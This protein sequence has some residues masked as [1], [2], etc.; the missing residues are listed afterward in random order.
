MGA[1]R[2]QAVDV[3]GHLCWACPAC[4]WR[5]L[6]VVDQDKADSAMQFSKKRHPAFPGCLSA[7][8]IEQFQTVPDGLKMYSGGYMRDDDGI[9]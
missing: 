4:G 2:E 1:M 7:F 3:N 8:D 9:I 6:Y 5:P